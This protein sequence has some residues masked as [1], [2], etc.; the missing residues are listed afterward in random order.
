MSTC[1]SML[2]QFALN[3][4]IFH[5]HFACGPLKGSNIELSET[6]GILYELASLFETCEES[7]RPFMLLLATFCM[8]ACA[9]LTSSVMEEILLRTSHV[10]C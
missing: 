8:I 9:Q 2:Q 4:K 7:I 5:H 6:W 1:P 10:P 3:I